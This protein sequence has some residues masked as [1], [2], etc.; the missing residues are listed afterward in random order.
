MGAEST[1]RGHGPSRRVFLAAAA[2]G[3][4]ASLL[5]PAGGAWAAT[6]NPSPKLPSEYFRRNNQVTSH[7]GTLYDDIAVRIN[8]D[9][10]RM[11][12]PQTIRPGAAPTTVVWLFHGS[13]SDHN[14]IV[15][16]F[17]TTAERIVDYGAIA[18]CQNA[19][20]TLYSH[21]TAQAAQVAGYAYLSGVYTVAG[22]VLR[23]TSGGGALA[24]ETA[25][26][27][28]IPNIR[29][30]YLVNA[31]YDIWSLFDGEGDMRNTIVA[32]FGEDP[33]AVDAANPARHPAAAWS[34]DKLRVVYSQ[35][36]GSDRVVP[37]ESH[38]KPLLAKATT[39]AAEATSRIHAYGHSTPPWANDDFIAA[40]DRWVPIAVAGPRPVIT[41]PTAGAVVSGIATVRATVT[42]SA[43]IT[44]VVFYAGA[45][46]VGPGRLV[47]GEWT[48]TANTAT[49]ATPDG[50]YA[51]TAVA[52]DSLGRT[53][54]SAPVGVTVR[55]AAAD[56]VAPAVAITSPP[57]GAVVAGNVTLTATASDA[58]GVTGVSFYAGTTLL[59]AGSFNGTAWTVT[60][61]SKT[62]ATPNGTY[63][64]RAV[65]TDAAGNTG[66]SS[67]VTIT[68]KN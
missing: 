43:A 27:G 41:S 28:L 1:Q 13:G 45:T 22:N 2:S 44:G 18:I 14:S 39:T 53:G 52:T 54:T 36:D 26:A 3:I 48:L 50:T 42:G 9:P 56:T 62:S 6:P 60:R 67:I 66:T 61:N 63:P 51:V 10:A 20:G 23:A 31:V 33:V 65:A 55:N 15:G 58:V 38:A 49:S 25:A 34:G 19:G 4:G 5:A 30:V 16:G 8:G 29:G 32:A 21:P 68:V 59:G 40:L 47:N 12:V 46:R 64:V 17:K 11:F 24:C 7:A 35:P 37:P 57:N